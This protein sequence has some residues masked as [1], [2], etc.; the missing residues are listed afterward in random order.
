[1]SSLDIYLTDRLGDKSFG[2][3]IDR[4]VF[5]FEIADF[6]KWGEF[7]TCSANY[8]S[9]RP[10]S[11]EMWSVGQLHWAEVKDLSASDQL[12][13]LRRALQTAIYR[14]GQKARKP[15]D[16]VYVAFASTVEALL[17]DAP[18]ELLSAKPAM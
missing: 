15:K 3:S 6:E 8:T 2:G 14:I 4:F 17:Q 18:V 1:M 5:C 9:Y 7:F 16:F 13:A 12:V 10:K 11:K